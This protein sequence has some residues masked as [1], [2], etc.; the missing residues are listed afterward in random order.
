M[1]PNG[2]EP[3]NARSSQPKQL[4]VIITPWR[5]GHCT[6]DL[7]VRTHSGGDH[8]DRRS[9]HLDL[10]VSPADLAGATARAVIATL[11]EHLVPPS[12]DEE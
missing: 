11:A 8:W 2:V 12:V 9:G 1:T 5:S 4:R 10:D 6:V 3:E 7:V